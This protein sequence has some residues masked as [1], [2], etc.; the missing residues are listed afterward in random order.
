MKRQSLMRMLGK[1]GDPTMNNL[2]AIVSHLQNRE[3]VSL[4]LVPKSLAGKSKASRK[5]QRS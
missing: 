3:R 2:F 4:D 1:S 5:M